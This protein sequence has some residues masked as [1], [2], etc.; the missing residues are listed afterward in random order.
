[1]PGD[2]VDPV[3]E[4]R[5]DGATGRGRDAVEL[6]PAQSAV[7]AVELLGDDDLLAGFEDLG[8]VADVLDVGVAV[9]RRE[10]RQGIPVGR[11][12]GGSNLVTP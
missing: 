4:V 6:R 11:A 5:A 10:G 3:G 8:E 12:K 2:R 9:E 7:L 1:M